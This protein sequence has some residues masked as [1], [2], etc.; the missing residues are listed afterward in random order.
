MTTDFSAQ[1][2]RDA[3]KKLFA[4]YARTPYKTDELPG[5][6]SYSYRNMAIGTDAQNITLKPKLE[7]KHRPPTLVNF[8]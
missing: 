5:P 2:G 4:L 3:Y 7:C 8:S 1:C 6:G